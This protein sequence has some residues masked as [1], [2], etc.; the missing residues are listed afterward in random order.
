MKR[1]HILLFLVCEIAM[2][3]CSRTY[4]GEE[5][6]QKPDVGYEQEPVPV[7]LSIGNTGY[8]TDTRS[9][10]AFGSLS[11]KDATEADILQWK[12]ARIYI[13]AFAKGEDVDLS[14]CWDDPKNTNEDIC[15]IDATR[16]GKKEETNTV[17][18]LKGKETY[19][20]QDSYA[21]LYW[22][23]SVN[24]KDLPI[25]YNTVNRERPYNFFAYYL[26]DAETGIIHRERDRIY[27]DVTINGQQD[28]MSSMAEPTKVQIESLKGNPNRQKMLDCAFSAYSANYRLDPVFAFKHRLTCLNFEIYPA[29][30]LEEGEQSECYHLEISSIKVLNPLTKGV[31]TVAT[32][33]PEKYPLGVDFIYAQ[34]D[35]PTPFIVQKK[36]ADKGNIKFDTTTGNLSA[37]APYWKEDQDKSPYYKRHGQALDGTVLLAPQ[38][39][40]KL[41]ISLTNLQQGSN[42]ENK[43]EGETF[44]L[45][46]LPPSGSEAFEEGKCY[47]VRL[48]IFG[49]QQIDSDVSLGEWKPGGNI[50]FKPE[51]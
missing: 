31:F 32:N 11:D 2:A 46:I 15:L 3:A 21:Y 5:A 37:S 6:I 45:D 41:Q 28:L 12:N 44:D 49:R 10:G 8:I 23:K 33:D 34:E 13:Y 1:I 50:D 51:G 26:D 48:G 47:T 36:Y 17:A 25:Y 7:T 9:T 27:F 22:N 19:I 14:T 24:D 40:Y 29:G 18:D 35:N 38:S 4:T 20:E 30:E 16:P 43:Y 42:N 39:L